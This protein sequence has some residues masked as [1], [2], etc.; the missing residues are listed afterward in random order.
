MLGDIFLGSLLY[1]SVVFSSVI[2]GVITRSKC[3][4]LPDCNV[5]FGQRFVLSDS[6]KAA[7]FS[8]ITVSSFI[9]F[10]SGVLG[11]VKSLFKS[12]TVALIFGIFLEVGGAS[13]SIISSPLDK[14]LILPLLA[15]S[16]AFSGLSVFFQALCFLPSEISRAKLLF[17]KLLQGILAAIIVLLLSIFVL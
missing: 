14:G 4:N 3:D 15:F 13:A 17:F 1:L 6:I 8:S 9:I 2:I 12:P 5:I 16:L 11:I 7:G 10:F